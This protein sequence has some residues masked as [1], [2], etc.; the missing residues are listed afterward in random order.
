M[1]TTALRIRLVSMM[2]LLHLLPASGWTLPCATARRAPSAGGQRRMPQVAATRG[3]WG[4]RPLMGTKVEAFLQQLAG[5]RLSMREIFNQ[6]DTTQDGMLR[7]KELLDAMASLKVDVSKREI[8]RTIARFDTDGDG[9]LSFVEFVR[10]LEALLQIP[11]DEVLVRTGALAQAQ[12]YT[13]SSLWLHTILTLHRS[14]LLRRI[15]RPVAAC[16]LWSALL[17]VLVRQGL[18]KPSGALG[19]LLWPRVHTLLGG[20]LGL[21]LV[22]RTNSAYSRM[23]E[24]R[25]IWERI[26][27]VC[28]DLSRFC[29]MNAQVIGRRRLGSIAHLL[30][31]C[32]VLLER[33]LSSTLLDSLEEENMGPSAGR[34]A[35]RGHGSAFQPSPVNHVESWSAR[36][37]PEN[38]RTRLD[39]VTNRPLH[40]CQA[41]ACEFQEI[42]NGKLFSS[43]ERLFA[44]NLVNKLSGCIGACE[45]IVQT[46]VP[47]SYARHTSRFLTIWHARKAAHALT[48]WAS[49]PP[50]PARS[51]LARGSPRRQVFHAAPVAR[52]RARIGRD[53]RHDLCG[54]VALRHTG[55]A[56]LAFGAGCIALRL[57]WRGA[58]LPPVQE[59]G[60]TIEQPFEEQLRTD[61]LIAAIV[62]DMQEALL[63]PGSIPV[64]VEEESTQAK[65]YT[66]PGKVPE[67]TVRISLRDG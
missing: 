62:C 40:I 15:V 36:N 38:V 9:A 7:K 50:Y 3:T 37:L 1:M 27:S 67:T 47:L 35:D 2:I 64:N 18:A 6:L 52:W 10:M 33:H 60:L 20:A 56:L 13:T 42:P 34:G 14:T 31:A 32:P 25:Q 65:Q 24:G 66:T 43:R 17:V 63:S 57:T 28:R 49:T 59:L 21:L 53:S 51:H 55:I 26:S 12:R 29:V 61:V 8:E 4:P 45:R 48:M 46:P 11:H 54:M 23:W 19:L 30:C 39:S 41:L 16:T 22:F 58:S 5:S 44:L